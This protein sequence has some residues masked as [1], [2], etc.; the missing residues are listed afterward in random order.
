MSA[1]SGPGGEAKITFLGDA[2]CQG[3]I[4]RAYTKPGGGYDF[5]ELFDG[6]RD[7]LA[8]SDYVVANL[9]TTIAPDDLDLTHERYSFCSPVA[10]AE[11]VLRELKG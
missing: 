2:M 6:V 1:M 3:P 5:S 7:F 10:F 8:A 4:L 11:A 9:E